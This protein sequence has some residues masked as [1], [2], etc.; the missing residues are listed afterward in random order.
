MTFDEVA[1]VLQ[2]GHGLAYEMMHFKLGFH[3]VCARWIPK[4]LTEVHKQ[5][6]LDSCQKHLGRYGNETFF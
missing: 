5:M 6:R 1:H 2:I 3:K 4:Q